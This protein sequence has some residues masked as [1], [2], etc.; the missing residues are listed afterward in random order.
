MPANERHEELRTALGCAPSPP[1]E[2]RVGE[3][4]PFVARNTVRWQASKISC[5][6]SPCLFCMF[7]GHLTLPSVAALPAWVSVV[8]LGRFV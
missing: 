2:E 7:R 4:R 1:L 6:A 3:R 8:N 5:G